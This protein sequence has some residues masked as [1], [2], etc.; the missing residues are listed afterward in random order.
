MVFQRAF[1]HALWRINGDFSLD[2]SAD[3]RIVPERHGRRAGSSDVE[4]IV[5]GG[6]VPGGGVVKNQLGRD[7]DAD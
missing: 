5:V 6:A 1:V 4:F 2:G 3:A 7:V